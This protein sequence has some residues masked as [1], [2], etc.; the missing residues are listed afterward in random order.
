MFLKVQ[1]EDGGRI[2]CRNI[3]IHQQN[4][5]TSY[6]KDLRSD[7]A[8]VILDQTIVLCIEDG[9]SSKSNNNFKMLFALIAF[10]MGMFCRC[11]VYG[12]ILAQFFSRSGRQQLI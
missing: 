1:A 12:L 10:R 4:R 2:F 6:G 3:G 7:T 5:M 8:L 11:F 9:V